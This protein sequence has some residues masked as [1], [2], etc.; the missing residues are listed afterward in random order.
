MS[1]GPC[2]SVYLPSS[3]PDPAIM[4]ADVNNPKQTCS[5]WTICP[6]GPSAIGAEPQVGPMDLRKNEQIF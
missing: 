4:T 5:R 2:L 6:T 1:A 3:I